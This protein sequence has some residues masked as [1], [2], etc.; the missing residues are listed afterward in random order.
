VVLLGDPL[1]YYL[2]CAF[3]P[4][5]TEL[6]KIAA[7]FE[8][9][10][11]ATDE[12]RRLYAR[13]I[14]TLAHRQQLKP[15]DRH[16]VARLMEH[17]ARMAGHRDKLSLRIGALVDLLRESQY[18][19]ARAGA[20]TVTATHVQAA[21]DA[22]VR[23]ADRGRERIHEEIARGTIMIDT[24]GTRVGQVNSLS[25]VA[26]GQFAFGRPNRITARVRLGEA[27]VVDIEREVELGGPI[28]SKGVL[29]LAAYVGARY[30]PERP[31]SLSASVVFEQSY[32]AVEGDSASVA[33]LLALLSAIANVPLRQSIAVTGSVNQHGEIQAIGAVN[34][35]VEGFFDVCR[36]RGLTGEHGVMIPAANVQHLMLRPD[37]VEAV[38]AGRFHVY[39]VK[40]VDEGVEL[41]TGM[42]AGQRT[43]AGEFPDESFNRL[44]EERLVALA[45]A[46]QAQLAMLAA[47]EHL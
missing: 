46:R 44:V 27:G 2:L 40:T 20:E 36:A 18:C 19:A 28:H 14:A 17:S 8:D 33:E 29:I 6:F 38:R 22:Q 45:D 42:A 43:A 10:L 16:A 5:F 11:S 23:R 15:L 3:D 30:A 24:A 1:I 21:I 7:D 31:L 39:A 13:L 34:E 47:R 12:N 41:L 35:K 32:A 25:V 37:V 9:S 4:D 26:L